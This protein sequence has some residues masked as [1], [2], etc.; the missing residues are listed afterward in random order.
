MIAPVR[1]RFPEPKLNGA[2]AVFSVMQ[3][4]GTWKP[5]AKITNLTIGWVKVGDVYTVHS[6]G[7]ITPIDSAGPGP[8]A[9][10]E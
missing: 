6:K 1:R 3:P 10:A 4:D 5:I 2:G 8:A 9:P 7:K